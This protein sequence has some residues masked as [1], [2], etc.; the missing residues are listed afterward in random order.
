MPSLIT[1]PQHKLKQRKPNPFKARKKAYNQAIYLPSNYKKHSCFPVNNA[2]LH[3]LKTKLNY[4]HEIR[5][6]K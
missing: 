5:N 6:K 4:G 3:D 1:R 2:L